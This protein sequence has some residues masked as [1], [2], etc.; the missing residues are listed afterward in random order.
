MR[1]EQVRLPHALGQRRIDADA[2]IA[3][4]VGM[5]VVEQALAAPRAADGKLETLGEALQ[6]G[7]RGFRPARAAGN[8]EGP[9]G[10]PQ[11]LLQ[12]GHLGQAGMGLDLG[13]RARIDPLGKL[14]QDVLGQRQHHRA[15]AARGRL[16]EG[17]ADHLAG[18]VGTV[19]LLDPLGHL[20][21]HAAEV[22]LLERL[23]AAHGAPDL[24]DEDDHRGR[25]LAADMDA[26]R[27]IGRTRPAR[28]HEDAGAAGELAPGLGRHRG[29]A[30][31]AAQRHGNG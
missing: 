15:G 1:S 28:H 12:F 5:L 26:G 2:D 6:G 8:H 9:F 3:G 30:L 10:A 18:T 14:A 11:H 17:A 13:P 4:I 25:I 7:N 19:D 31:L 20:A 16:V 22:D 21:E 24:A 23:A 27:R 29:A